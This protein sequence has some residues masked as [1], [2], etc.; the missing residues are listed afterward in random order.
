[1]DYI[2]TKKFL[3]RV[4]HFTI[5]IWKMTTLEVQRKLIITGLPCSVEG[6]ADP[7]L[8]SSVPLVITS[9]SSS[10]ERAMSYI[11]QQCCLTN[12]YSLLL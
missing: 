5:T 12:E 7:S 10:S 8:C 3:Q 11:T 4:T 9:W 6:V 1:M 2:E